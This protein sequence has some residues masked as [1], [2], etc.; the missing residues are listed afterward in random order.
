MTTDTGT[1]ADALAVEEATS[2]AAATN[3]P[4][5]LGVPCAVIG[6]SAL[7][8]FLLGYAPAGAAGALLPL[9]LALSVG[10]MIAARWAIQG[11]VGP[12]ASI[13]GLFAAFFL[14]F[15]LL[16]VGHVHNWY[17]T[18]SATASSAEAAAA[19]AGSFNLYL[20]CWIIGTTVLVAGTLRL[21]LAITAVLV[22]SDL[23]FVFAWLAFITGTFADGGVLR[24]IGGVACLGIV[25]SG[26]YVFYG[27][28]VA[29]LGG[30]EVP[31]GRPVLR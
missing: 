25:V 22:F 11:G 31:M 1:A 13:F 5:L 6:T 8:L 3:N 29:A 26:A 7:A 27:A 30:K 24:T 15:V 9:F 19:L 17:G 10:L 2:P 23:V 4:V 20:L 21:P 14:S 16:Y 12:V 28:M 18:T